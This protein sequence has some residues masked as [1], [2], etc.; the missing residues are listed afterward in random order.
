MSVIQDWTK[1]HILY[2]AEM[3]RLAEE[4]TLDKVLAGIHYFR[5]H[6]YIE[7]VALVNILPQ[8]VAQHP[9]VCP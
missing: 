5:C 7:L 4:F 9:K 6:D 8:F 2:H 3:R 1:M